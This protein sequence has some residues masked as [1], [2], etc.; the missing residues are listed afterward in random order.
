MEGMVGGR[1][2]VVPDEQGCLEALDDGKLGFVYPQGNL[3]ACAEVVLQALS[4]DSRVSIARDFAVSNYSWNSI[5]QKIDAV[6]DGWN[7]P[8]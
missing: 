8:G 2:V 1:T 6:Y 4:D 5:L 7:P 3:S